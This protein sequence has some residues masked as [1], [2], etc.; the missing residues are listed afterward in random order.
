[1]ATTVLQDPDDLSPAAVEFYRQAM[2]ILSEAQLPFL[3]GGGYALKAHTGISRCTKDLDLFVSP[4]NIEG[5]LAALSAAGMEVELKFPHWLGKARSDDHVVDLIFS[6]GNGLCPV[7][8]RWFEFALKGELLGLSV[9]FTPV[10]EMI[11]QKAFI[12]ERHRYDGADI[13]HLLHCCGARLDWSR[14]IERFA[15]HWKLLLSHLLIADFAYPQMVSPAAK[16]AT[17]QLAS[18]L[19]RESASIDPQ[20]ATSRGPPVCHGTFLSLFEYLPALELWGYR[21]ARLP[22]TGAMTSEQI[23]HWTATVEK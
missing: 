8:S 7:D 11:W 1:M 10:E 16:E 20:E 22:P 4:G 5:A 14:L 12:M 6:S 3:V 21:D 19:L 9:L 13:V 2:L 17:A 15:E 23:D 18:R